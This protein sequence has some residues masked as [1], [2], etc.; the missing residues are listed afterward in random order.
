MIVRLPVAVYQAT[1]TVDTAD[2][3]PDSDP[4]PLAR[5]IREALHLHRSSQYHDGYLKM[6]ASACEGLR[7]LCRDVGGPAMVMSSSYR[8]DD[9]CG[10]E[11]WLNVSIGSYRYS[12]GTYFGSNP[13]SEHPHY[14]QGQG[15]RAILDSLVARN[16]AGGI[17]PLSRL[18]YLRE[19]GARE[20]GLL[21][22]EDGDFLMIGDSVEGGRGIFW[23]IDREAGFAVAGVQSG[24]H[25]AEIDEIVD[26]DGCFEIVPIEDFAAELL[27]AIEV[28]TD[29]PGDRTKP[30]PPPAM[31]V[32]RYATEILG[33]L[34]GGDVEAARSKLVREAGMSEAAAD[35]WIATV[36]E[37]MLKEREQEETFEYLTRPKR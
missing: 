22:R 10:D 17:A 18:P 21:V 3:L 26:G 31:P 20:I 36:H 5:A 29:W 14:E 34:R 4:A 32:E 24:G 28:G 27:V 19:N 15:A 37:Q 2:T 12:N 7:A 8:F 11:Y 33:L 25:G 30:I 16:W 9:A 6:T 1:A 13:G 35:G 23:T